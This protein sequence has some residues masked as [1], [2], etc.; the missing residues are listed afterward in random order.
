MI[1]FLAPVCRAA[2]A[3]LDQLSAAALQTESKEL[4][5]YETLGPIVNTCKVGHVPLTVYM[6][7][8]NMFLTVLDFAVASGIA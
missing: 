3:H 4:A 8:K 7:H 2:I 1:Q 6:L 5:Q